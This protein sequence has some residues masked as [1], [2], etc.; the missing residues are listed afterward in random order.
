L[1]RHQPFEII[2][3]HSGDREIGLRVLNG[4]THLLHS[5]NDWDW[6]GSGIYFWEQNPKRTLNYAK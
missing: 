3:Y 6:L 4:E 2:G 1:V 5:D